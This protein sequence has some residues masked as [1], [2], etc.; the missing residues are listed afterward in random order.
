MKFVR[1]VLSLYSVQL[2][3]ISA[4]L[5]TYLLATADRTGVARE[6]PPTIEEV[7]ME[8]TVV[9]GFSEDVSADGGELPSGARPHER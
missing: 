8:V 9:A 5:M 4:L 2:I 7:K 6:S 1:L 3:V